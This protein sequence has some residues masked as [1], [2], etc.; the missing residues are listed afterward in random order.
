MKQ[1][2]HVQRL[3]R[4]LL[5]PMPVGVPRAFE[6]KDTFD[7]NEEPD[8]DLRY[9]SDRDEPD[10]SEP[11]TDYEISDFGPATSVNAAD[12]PPDRV[13]LFA[14]R[15]EDLPLPASRHT[16]RAA[17]PPP[18]PAPLLPPTPTTTEPPVDEIE[19]VDLQHSPSPPRSPVSRS[20]RPPYRT[21][22]TLT[23]TLHAQPL[24][25]WC[26]G[27]PP[28]EEGLRQS[29]PTLQKRLKICNKRANFINQQLDL[30]LPTDHAFKIKRRKS[31]NTKKN[32]HPLTDLQFKV[33]DWLKNF[34][35]IFALHINAFRAQEL[36][37][38]LAQ[39]QRP[40]RSSSSFS[41]G[42]VM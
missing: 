22:P 13:D 39:P 10:L 12:P 30:I 24:T 6:F 32:S 38:T 27:P 14:R 8:F 4:Y 28:A 25:T 31:D 40:R 34:R 7:G 15:P 3:K 5:Q 33:Q 1:L 19:P 20:S 11:E 17:A 41:R 2:I 9:N 29:P 36:Q 16:M 23:T 21:S 26:Y 42:G 18:P 35:N 37:S